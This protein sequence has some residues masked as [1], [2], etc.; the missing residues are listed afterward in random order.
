MTRALAPALIVLSLAACGSQPPLSNPPGDLGK[1]ATT[2][3][4]VAA[5][6]AAAPRP[7]PAAVTVAPPPLLPPA[8]VSMIGVWIERCSSSSSDQARL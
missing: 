6:V 7:A 2:T 8:A 3:P 4:E 5:L 1:P